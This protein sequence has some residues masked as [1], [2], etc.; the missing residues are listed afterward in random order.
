V[1]PFN[2]DRLIQMRMQG[3]APQGYIVVSYVGYLD[4]ENFVLM[5]RAQRDYDWRC[6]KGLDTLVVVGD[7]PIDVTPVIEACRPGE[8]AL[9]VVPRQAGAWLYLTPKLTPD[10]TAIMGRELSPVTFPG[11]LNRDYS[12]RFAVEF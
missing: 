1:T 3:K 2:A 4:V 9:W 12:Q 5:A 8:C 10:G 11:C 7:D 6:L